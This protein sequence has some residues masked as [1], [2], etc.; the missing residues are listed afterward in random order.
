EW[1]ARGRNWLLSRPPERSPHARG[2]SRFRDTPQSTVCAYNRRQGARSGLAQPARISTC[3]SASCG[4]SAGICM[5]A[6]SPT[7]TSSAPRIC[8]INLANGFRGG[9]RQTEL[10][11]KEMAGRSWLQRL[12]VRK[13]G[14]LAKRC[15]DVPGLEIAE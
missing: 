6:T 4:R 15:Q 13:D 10:L 8:H 3:G 5:T 1:T 11:V 9:E 2:R 14:A 7:P 12:V